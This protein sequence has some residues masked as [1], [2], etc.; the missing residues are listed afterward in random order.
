MFRHVLRLKICTVGEATHWM[1]GS[2]L[3]KNTCFCP[4]RV[5]LVDWVLSSELEVHICYYHTIKPLSSLMHF[6][7]ITMQL[8]HIYG[9]RDLWGPLRSMESAGCWA[10]HS[11]SILISIVRAITDPWLNGLIRHSLWAQFILQQYLLLSS[12][13]QA[14]PYRQLWWT[15]RHV[16]LRIATIGVSSI[17]I[18][19]P[20]SGALLL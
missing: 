16:V 1:I 4:R 15:I 5:R 12:F 2:L 18:L 20:S 3:I 13:Y 9:R 6:C 7:Y 14:S 11:M 17:L 19:W 10:I 8:S